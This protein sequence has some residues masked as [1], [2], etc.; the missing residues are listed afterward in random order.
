MK[1]EQLLVQYLYKN[2]SVSLQDIGHFT[3]SPD[4]AI[5]AATEKEAVL[6]DGAIQFTYDRKATQDEGLIAYI[7]EQTRKIRPLAISD[8]ESYGNL[9][10]Q[11]LNIGKPMV[12][13][14]LGTLVKSQEDNFEFI[15]GKTVH[16]KLQTNNVVIKEK[17]QDDISFST[18]EK[19]GSSKKGLL[20]GIVIV[21]ILSAAAAIYYFTIYSK[22]KYVP[23]EQTQAVVP[24]Q[25][26]DTASAN[27]QTIID[28]ADKAIMQRDSI[29]AIKPADG[30][31]FKIILKDY[32]TK[33]A[34]DNALKR[35][36]NYGHAVVQLQKDDGSYSL[37]MPFTTPISD[38]TRAVDSLRKFFGGKPYVQL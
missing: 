12:I 22:D 24:A 3:L 36:T 8:L 31:S 37:A 30:Y 27:N 38:T 21:F 19:T 7:V 35:L 16:P 5:P 15:Q 4:V 9:S 18:P 28:S 32:S 2:K 11:F 6:P 33:L 14:G 34:A 29:T 26:L 13:E 1:I 23:V 20:A 25:T 10:R 17:L